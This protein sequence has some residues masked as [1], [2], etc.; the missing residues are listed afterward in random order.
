METDRV[1][2]PPSPP[3]NGLEA[4]V[5]DA[6]DAQTSDVDLTPADPAG[7]RG[8]PRAAWRLR[9][10]YVTGVMLVVVAVTVAI[11]AHAQLER[12]DSS[13]TSARTRLHHTLALLATARTD[14]TTVTD[15]SE[16]AGHTVTSHSAQ[17]AADQAQLARAQANVFAKE[18]NISELDTC[19]AGVQKSRT[20]ISLGDQGGAT[21]TLNG[22]ASNCRDAEPSGS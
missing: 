20:L 22:V 15:Q 11:D 12:T 8:R 9:V 19:L 7:A 10:A 3:A 4:M 18:V 6:D 14:I 17:L 5:P 2:V 13:L 1:R 16:S 21:A